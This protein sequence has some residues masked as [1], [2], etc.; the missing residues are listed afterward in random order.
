LVVDF[1]S[2]LRVVFAGIYFQEKAMKERTKYF[3][4]GYSAGC[5]I[6]IIVALLI[7]NEWRFER[8]PQPGACVVHACEECAKHVSARIL[9]VRYNEV[10]EG[11]AYCVY[12][13]AGRTFGWDYRGAVELDTPDMAT[14]AESVAVWLTVI[15]PPLPRVLTVRSAAYEWRSK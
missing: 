10:D 11:H 15:D 12:D 1:R 7:L 6:W 4:A 8:K 9:M 14:D 13:E 3:F 2:V 5:A